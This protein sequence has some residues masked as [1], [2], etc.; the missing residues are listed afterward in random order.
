MK[1]FLAAFLFVAFSGTVMADLVDLRVNEL[2]AD[3]TSTTNNFDTD[4]DG[5]AETTDEFIEFYNANSTSSIDISA[6]E[7]WVGSGGALSVRHTFATGTIIAPGGFLVAV[8]QWNSG[9]LPAGFVEMDA[10]GG[11]ILG[12]GGD[13]F[14]IYDPTGME[15]SS[16]VYNGDADLFGSGLPSGAT[17]LGMTVDL[18]SDTDGLSM[19][20][21]PDGSESFGIQG[22]T[23]GAT[24]VAVPEPSSMTA[25]VFAT[26]ALLG[27]RRRS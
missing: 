27:Y 14:A 6:Y 21:L 8:N 22:P 18:G 3:P 7:L 26:L 24:N 2:L 9:N 23:P 17:Q 5:D 15:Y 1:Y 16:Y 19:A 12:N 20:A 10:G 25:V 11:G 13:N 4:G